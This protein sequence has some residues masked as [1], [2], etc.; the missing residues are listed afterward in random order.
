MEIA[1]EEELSVDKVL[2]NKL[3][4]NWLDDFD[5]N[6]DLISCY[7]V[8]VNQSGV[9]MCKWCKQM[10]KYGSNGKKSILEHSVSKKHKLN[11]N[12]TKTNQTLPASFQ[13]LLKQNKETIRKSVKKQ[14]KG[15]VIHSHVTPL[16]KNKAKLGL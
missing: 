10:I 11:R 12:I 2:K 13:T 8:K 6:G 14:S 15:K 9:A 16:Q 3:R 1:I 5:K 4:W 7:L